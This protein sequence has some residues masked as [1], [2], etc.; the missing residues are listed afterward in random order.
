MADPAGQA[1]RVLADRRLDSDEAAPWLSLNEAARRLGTS[2]DAL[3]SKA[4]RGQVTTRRGTDRRLLVQVPADLRLGSD[5]AEDGEAPRLSTDELHHEIGELRERLG[6]LEA[7]RDAQ[8][9]IADARVREAQAEALAK[10][11]VIAD[12]REALAWHRRPWWSRWLAR[13]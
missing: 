13:Q 6:R 9:Q 11:Q 2:V 3:R 5:E 12:L 1:G 8:Q 10:D 7:E 4:R